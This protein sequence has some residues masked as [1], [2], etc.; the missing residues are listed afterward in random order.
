VPRL[1][2]IHF[3]EK[4]FLEKKIVY[5]ELFTN[6][7]GHL[8]GGRA[9]IALRAPKPFPLRAKKNF[10]FRPGQEPPPNRLDSV[11]IGGLAS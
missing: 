7:D 10:G 9:S 4:N 2:R 8:N 1:N 3:I 11:T 6:S 5:P